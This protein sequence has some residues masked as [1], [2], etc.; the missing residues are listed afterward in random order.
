[1]GI[2][3]PDTAATYDN[4]GQV[5]YSQ[6]DYTK[7]LEYYFKALDIKEKVLGKEHPSTATSYNNIGG[8]Y[9]SQGDY[10]KALEY[11]QKAFDIRKQKLGSDHPY[12]KGT[13][14]GLEFCQFMKAKQDGASE[15]DL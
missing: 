11:L 8:G 14:E 7:A 9:Y 2:E 1:M 5:Y 4:I 12:T 6:G 10:T 3:H 15:E 13:K